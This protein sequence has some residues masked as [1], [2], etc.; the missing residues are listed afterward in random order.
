MLVNDTHKLLMAALA[1]RFSADHLHVTDLPYRFCSWALDD[2]ENTRMWFNAHGELLAWAVL[3][4]P[5]WLLDY[6]CD[7]QDSALHREILAWGDERARQALDTPYG[8]PAW[9]VNVF[10]DQTGRQRDLEAARFTSQANVSEDSWTKVF[11]LRPAEPP[12]KC[13]RLPAGFTVRPL[14][15]ESEVEAYGSLHRAVFET[16]N[17]T[18]EWRSRTLQHPDYLPDL[19]I[20]VAAPDGRLAAF[21]V[22]WFDPSSGRGQIEP[23]G[24]HQD[25]RQYALGRVALAE[26]L[27]RLQAHGAQQIYVETDHYRNTAFALY[28][29]MGF[30]V[31][32]E[33]LVYRKDYG[34]V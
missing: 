13:Y 26:V 21:C 11:M 29:H 22:G 3:Q 10:S 15:G 1:R 12:V 27:R 17:M 5:F 18:A 6:V 7:P 25:F 8:H 34:A 16:K 33:V 9:F 4:T 30:R 20:V 32:R 19:D 23:L 2:P 14:A 24:C 31:T 28:E